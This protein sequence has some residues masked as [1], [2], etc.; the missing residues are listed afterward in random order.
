[1]ILG[2]VGP[3][4]PVCGRDAEHDDP[5][6]PHWDTHEALAH[7]T[8]TR[9]RTDPEHTRTLAWLSLALTRI[10][11][12]EPTPSSYV[13]DHILDDEERLREWNGQW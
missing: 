6:P 7:L 2:D 8:K 10:R 11:E 3:T 9:L 12:L 4:C 5:C 1:M 13:Q